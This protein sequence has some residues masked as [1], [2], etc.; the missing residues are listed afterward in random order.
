MHQLEKRRDKMNKNLDV[1]AIQKFPN[2]IYTALKN[3]KTDK[4]DL[5]LFTNLDCKFELQGQKVN[6]SFD[7]ALYY[8]GED[9]DALILLMKNGVASPDWIREYLNKKK[10]MYN[11]VSF[12]SKLKEE[13]M[14]ELGIMVSE[15]ETDQNI[16]ELW[17][18]REEYVLRDALTDS[19][20]QGNTTCNYYP[21]LEGFLRLG[22]DDSYKLH[23]YALDGR[24]IKGVITLEDKMILM[25]SGQDPRNLKPNQVYA[26]MEE[27]NITCNVLS[28]RQFD[29]NNPVNKKEKAKRGKL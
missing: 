23:T 3:I 10:M 28:N 16:P 27:M 1:W 14:K 18:A 29:I 4:N 19:I 26:I 24:R 2:E 15:D 25:I 11:E 17:F 22:Y 13:R 21:L 5:I 12:K 9:N 7:T 8:V 20:N 6:R